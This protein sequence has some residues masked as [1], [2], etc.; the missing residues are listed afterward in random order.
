MWCT[1][2][3]NIYVYYNTVMYWT[4]VFISTTVVTGKHWIHCRLP[5][6]FWLWNVASKKVFSNV[7]QLLNL[8]ITQVFARVSVK[9]N[10]Y[11]SVLY[12]TMLHCAVLCCMYLA[13]LHLFVFKMYRKEN[14]YICLFLKSNIKQTKFST[15]RLLGSFEPIFYFNCEHVLFV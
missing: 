10:L 8:Q 1:V 6:F 15:T 11:Y 7:C 12:C 5:Y 4:L 2:L 3:Y 13:V 14:T 9:M